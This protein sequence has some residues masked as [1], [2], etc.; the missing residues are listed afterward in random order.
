MAPDTTPTEHG[1]HGDHRDDRDRDH[2]DHSST[3]RARRRPH[4]PR[5]TTGRP[6]T[7][8]AQRRALRREVPG[9]VGVLTDAHDFQAMRGYDTFPFD[10]H[11]AYLRHVE[12]LLTSRAAGGLHTS[13]ALFDPDDFAEYCTDEGIA[14][15]AVRSR[16]RF[17]ASVA[18]RGDALTYTGQPLDELLPRLI[19]N[20]VRRATWEYAASLL[21]DIGA[22]AH[23]GEDIG[24]ASF[25]RAFHLLSR[26]LEAAGPGAHHLVCSVLAPEEHLLAALQAERDATSATARIDTVA[27]TEFVTVLATAVALDRPA[28]V[29][30]RTTTEEDAPVR[31]HGWRLHASSL[32]PLTEAEVFSAYCTDATTGEPVSPEPNVEYRAG[33][34][35]PTDDPDSHR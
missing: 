18:A 26:L 11:P 4:R 35:V 15:D 33:F 12:A 9:T 28:G 7:R 24:K 23:C 3:P 10:D 22:C 5:R 6:R 21:A 27:L 30:L 20:A 2:R 25:D 8:A 32:V 31:L 17:T 19:D 1:D 16:S 14:P 13:V 29:V 34:E